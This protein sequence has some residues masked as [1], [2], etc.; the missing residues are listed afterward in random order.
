MRV[1]TSQVVDGVAAC[2]HCGKKYAGSAKGWVHACRDSNTPVPCIHLGPPTGQSVQNCGCHV[3]A[4]WKVLYECA[5]HGECVLRKLHKK[6]GVK[7][8]Q[9]CESYEAG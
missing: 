5:V 4:S 3:P 9:G 7:A 1:I 2:E 6:P 8:C